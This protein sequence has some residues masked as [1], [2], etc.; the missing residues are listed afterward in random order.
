[1]CW[2]SVVVCGEMCV[3]GVCACVHAY[4]KPRIFEVI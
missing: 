1:M 3:V 4:Q 2:C